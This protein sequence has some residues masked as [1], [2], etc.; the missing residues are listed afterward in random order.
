MTKLTDLAARTAKPQTKS[1][2]LFAGGGLYLEV[3]PQGAKYW[4][5][6]YRIAGREK[7]LALGVYPEVTLRDATNRRDEHRNALR[8]GRDP[9]A[10]RQADK[11]RRKVAAD[12]SFETVAREWL[13]VKAHEWTRR[14]HEKERD[15][16]QNHAFPW[17]GKLPIADIGVT[18]LRPI[19]SRLV[20]RGHLE[21]SHRLRHQL[22]R[23]FRY[24]VATERSGRDPAADLRDT[25]PARSKQNYAAITDPAKVGELL[26]AID[27]FGGTFP[28][29]CALKLAA[30][31]FARPGEIRAAEWAEFNLEGA[32]WTIPPARRKLKKAQKDNPNTPPH[33]VP[34]SKQAISIL[35]ELHPLTG[36]GCYLFPG[37]R[38]TRR[39][40]SDNT[41]NAALRRLGYDKETMT[42]HGF[43]HL[44]S[45]RLNE[46]GW[47]A[48]VIERQLSHKEPGVRGVYNKAEHLP[49]RR[50]MM[51][52]WA[53]YLDGLRTGANVIRIRRSA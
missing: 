29:A 6:K 41:I 1:Y 23:V 36:A 20:K 18:E 8:A 24:A 37:A 3:T 39:P 44:A 33:I 31:W 5:L 49:E 12:N 25:L 42:G 46:L 16:L 15:R 10:E 50:K 11:V 47:N 22:S 30:L 40:M 9:S 28:T 7:R 43:R 53:D 14:Q 26:R 52:A 2:R 27:A 4:R 13:D 45:T 38:D 32:Q 19:L 48:D 17:I 51:Q 21:Q 35:R 34:L